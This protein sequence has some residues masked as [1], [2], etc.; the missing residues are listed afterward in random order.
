MARR[1]ST[2]RR[3]RHLAEI[4][5]LQEFKFSDTQWESI[6]AELG[7]AGNRDQW[8]LAIEE[9]ARSLLDA[10]KNPEGYPGKSPPGDKAAMKSVASSARRLSVALN[11]LSGFARCDLEGAF[12]DHSVENRDRIARGRRLGKE[13]RTAAKV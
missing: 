12:R 2:S 7:D 5:P 1:P 3:S 6:A 8:R 11:K 13:G 9:S 4:V 10:R